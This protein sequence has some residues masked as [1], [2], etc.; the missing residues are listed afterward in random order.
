MSALPREPF[1]AEEAAAARAYRA[2][3]AGEPSPE[4]DAR[5]LAHVRTAGGARRKPRP[6]FFGAGLGTAAAA[7]MAAGLAWQLGW[8]G[9]DGSG[10]APS[11]QRDRAGRAMKVEVVDDR[12]EVEYVELERPVPVAAPA[13]QAAAE[14]A[15]ADVPRRQAPPPRSATPPAPPPAAP[16]APPAPVMAP[17]PEPP[18]PEIVTSETAAAPPQAFPAEA[19]GADA[20]A[21]AASAAPEAKREARAAE[22][23]GL[24]ASDSRQRAASLPPW[25]T[26]DALAPAAWIE[27]IRDRVRAGD[28]QGA[29]HSLRR[30]KLTHPHRR[31]PP[32]LQRLLVE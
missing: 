25:T 22:L 11:T 32:E 1:D 9:P 23:G 3:P 17:A 5:I 4:L 2:L 13:P 8:L 14:K 18:P 6:W 10:R 24:R 7:V 16:A 28:R 31:V 26:D 27:R 30:F 15:R 12:V 21:G 29:E 19:S 20:A